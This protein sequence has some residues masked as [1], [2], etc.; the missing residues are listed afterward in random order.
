VSTEYDH[1]YDALIAAGCQVDNHE[2]DL[3]VLATPEARAI[4]QQYDKLTPLAKPFRSQIDGRIWYDVPF[5]YKPFWD[6][7]NE[8]ARKIGGGSC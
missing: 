8:R 7:V 6:K 4:L 1:V 5:M 2:S 3:Y